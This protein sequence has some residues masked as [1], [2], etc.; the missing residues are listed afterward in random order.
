MASTVDSLCSPHIRSNDRVLWRRMSAPVVRGH[1]DQ[2]QG[3]GM[4]LERCTPVPAIWGT[5]DPDWNWANELPEDRKLPINLL[6]LVED[7]WEIRLVEAE[8]E[9]K[10]VPDARLIPNSA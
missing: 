2:C 10:C 4:Y 6:Q 1:T 8:G 3:S 9:L 7:R 5:L